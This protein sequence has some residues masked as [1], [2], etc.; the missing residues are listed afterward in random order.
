MSVKRDIFNTQRASARR[1][2]HMEPAIR[3]FNTDESDA[4]PYA[5]LIVIDYDQNTSVHVVCASV[6]D[7]KWHLWYFY[8]IM[9]AN[10]ESFLS[11]D[12]PII[13]DRVEFTIIPILPLGLYIEEP[14][15]IKPGR[16]E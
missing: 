2:E 15:Q 1:L 7:V 3:L 14:E 5:H 13:H 16:K 6:A 9:P 11:D 10:V 4:V 12:L 8:K